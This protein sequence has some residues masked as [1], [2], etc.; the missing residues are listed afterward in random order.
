M[1]QILD[2]KSLKTEIDRLRAEGK[3][4]VFTNGCFDIIHIGHV[5]YLKNA[6]NLGNV[7]IVGLNSD[8]SVAEIKP[9]RPVNT[10]SRRAEVLA[11]LDMVDYV[12]IFDEDTPYEL[13]K[14]IK[15]D[16]LVKGGDWKREDIV[17]SDIVQDVYSLPYIE[18]VSTTELIEKI[19]NLYP[20]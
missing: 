1:G 2:W 10:E 11:S 8:S 12:T 15:P 9:G 19:R 20:L 5:R 7:L 16:V 4:I 17:G 3:K 13:I 6:K 18:G 14:H